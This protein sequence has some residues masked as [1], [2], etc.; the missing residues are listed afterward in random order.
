MQYIQISVVRDARFRSVDGFHIYGDG[1]SGVMD[2]VHPVTA[3]RLLFWDD[4]LQIAA[5]LLGGY[6]MGFHLDSIRKEGHLSGTHLLDRHELPA[7][8]TRVALGPFV[9]GRF[10]HAVVTEDEL[11]NRKQ[12][13]VVVHETLVNSAPSAAGHL[14]AAGFD[15]QTG[16]LTLSF[17][18]SERLIG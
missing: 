10:R 16:V 14:K 5:H 3:R 4:A 9:F 13:G 17:T 7:G 11:G 2:W 1:G 6:L 18:P 12:A 8:T 15:K